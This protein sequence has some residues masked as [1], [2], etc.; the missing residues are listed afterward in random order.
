VSV[1]CG[2][3]AVVGALFEGAAPVAVALFEGA[4]AAGAG[5]TPE[6][7]ESLQAVNRRAAIVRSFVMTTA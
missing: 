6:V 5:L 4:G 3:V 7:E 1:F 2:V